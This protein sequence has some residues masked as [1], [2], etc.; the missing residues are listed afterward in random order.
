MHPD[1]LGLSS[2]ETKAKEV[3]CGIYIVVQ[4]EQA[5]VLCASCRQICTAEMDGST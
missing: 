5:A 2:R 3:R 4:L 1:D